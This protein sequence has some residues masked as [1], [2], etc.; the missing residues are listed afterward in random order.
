[1]GHRKRQRS[2]SSSGSRRLVAQKNR[3]RGI[4]GRAK[5]RAYKEAGPD[6]ASEFQQLLADALASA[7]EVGGE[8]AD[9]F[10]RW[11]EAQTRAQVPAL[12]TPAVDSQLSTETVDR[13][14][15]GLPFELAWAAKL[16]MSQVTS[17]REF[18]SL[19]EHLEASTLSGHWAEA[20]STLDSIEQSYGQSI[21]AVEARVAIT[22]AHRGLDAQKRYLTSIRKKH[23]PNSLPAYLGRLYSIRNEPT[24]TLNSFLSDAEERIQRIP[25][26]ATLRSYL[27]FKVIWNSSFSQRELAG[28]LSIAQGLSVYD[29]FETFINVAQYALVYCSSP[30][31]NE[32]LCQVIGPLANET[33]DFRLRKIAMLLGISDGGALKH[34]PYAGAD[35]AM[36]NPGR[37][38]LARCVRELRQFPFAF[39]TALLA[40]SN[41]SV[42]P[43]SLFHGRSVWGQAI[44]RLATLFQFG[45]DY[46]G[47]LS[48]L[49]RYLRNFSFSPVLRAYYFA[50]RSMLADDPEVRNRYEFLVALNNRYLDI[51]ELPL[52]P[53]HLA[54]SIR[55][56]SGAGAPPLVW[57]AVTAQQ[58]ASSLPKAI[59]T[60]YAIYLQAVLA[61]KHSLVEPLAKLDR[62]CATVE[63][64]ALTVL[65]RRLFLITLF[66]NLQTD[67]GLE[68]AIDA[69]FR[70]GVPTALLPLGRD[71]AALRWKQLKP[72]GE[73]LE[74]S[75][76][77]QIAWRATGS[78]LVASNLRSAYAEFLTAHGLSSPTEMVSLGKWPVPLVI[79]F[80]RYVAVSDVIDMSAPVD[81]SRASREVRRD[82]C[83]ALIQLDPDSKAEYEAETFVITR[84]LAVQDG[85]RVLDSSR[86]HVD[87][88]AITSW[89]VREWEPTFARYRALVDAGI[90]ISEKLEDILRELGNKTITAKRFLILPDSDA[91]LILADLISGLRQRFLYDPNHGLDSYLSRRVRHHSMAGYL[92]GA[93]ENQQLVTTKHHSDRRY[94]RNEIW[95]SKIAR[96]SDSENGELQRALGRFCEEF[97]GIVANL[98]TD[99]LRI[100]SD[101]HPRGI[102]AI[103]ITP[104]M[105]HITRSVAQLSLTVDAFCSVCYPIF[106]AALTPALEQARSAL[107][108][109]TYNAISSAFHRLKAALRKIFSDP[110][111]Y[112]A[113]SVAIQGASEDINRKIASISE[114]F[115]RS[116]SSQSSQEYPLEQ[117]L[118]ICVQSAMYSYK[119]FVPVLSISVEPNQVISAVTLVELSDL[120]LTMLGNVRQ[121]SKTSKPPRVSITLNGLGD[122]GLSL[123][124][125]SDVNRGA[126]DDSAVARV[127]AIRAE[128]QR[129]TYIEQVRNE[130]NSGLIKIASLA[131]SHEEGKWDFGFDFGN[132]RFYVSV[133]IPPSKPVVIDSPLPAGTTP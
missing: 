15:K 117:A 73:L 109:D 44:R 88:G 5:S 55:P 125:E 75:I 74:L 103:T 105:F 98:K 87:T 14:P 81:S 35:F 49:E 67:A 43:S 121:H 66:E 107:K 37:S 112:A 86:V 30:S 120:I 23:S 82:V 47:G 64:R 96:I 110:D 19:A 122:G 50:T 57:Q 1:M 104:A 20:E 128:I 84:E 17:I 13:K 26:N 34:R 91:D 93:V 22:Q 2:H 127:E 72:Y 89:A 48:D 40:A 56:P 8:Q 31:L 95:P 12:R 28:V 90:G 51:E 27:R 102:F 108:V 4:I 78:D 111:R 106:W 124:M 119:P 131:M 123:R 29:L 116:E 114:W 80:L 3:I 6:K 45:D 36:S 94:L 42:H 65:V 70:L 38:A 61:N 83:S 71:F 62:S 59:A 53:A 9:E 99:L 130:G 113:L 11:V 52:Y 129:G 118:D 77:L 85:M 24:T 18:R 69:Y 16:L 21:W 54:A 115:H 63:S 10:L 39:R 33:G 32:A 79:Y 7:H 76:A 41:A 92:R 60:R 100:K 97:D 46:A 126:C 68:A 132:C 101:T 133:Q 58:S 25:L